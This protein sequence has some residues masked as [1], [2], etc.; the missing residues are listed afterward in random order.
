MYACTVYMIPEILKT[1]PV[2][3]NRSIFKIQL[4]N[5]PE[6]TDI[7][8]VS[9]V[10]KRDETTID[11][12]S[13]LLRLGRKYKKADL[14][15]EEPV[16][17]PVEE[18]LIR[19]PKE[20]TKAEKVALDANNELSE[21]IEDLE[22]R[23]P[24]STENLS[25]KASSYYMTN[26]KKY[27]REINTLFKSYIKDLD[28]DK[29]TLKC[30]AEQSDTFN[31]LTHQKIVRDYINIYTPYRG[32]LLY[33]GLGSGKTCSSIAIAEGMKSDRRI[34]IMT[35]ASL[36]MNFFNE[37]KHCGDALYKKNQYWEFV[38]AKDVD[39]IKILSTTLQLPKAYVKKHGGAW[40]V[41]VR[42]PANFSSLGAAEQ[43]QLDDQLNEMIRTKYTDI[44]YNGITPTIM[45]RITGK[46]TRNPFDNS[47]VV[48]DEAHNFVSRIVNK[49]KRKSS[50]TYKL[51]NY[52][53]TAQNARLVFLS[54][55]PIINYPNEIAVLYNMLRG[56][57]VS[58][59][60]PITN[61]SSEKI[62]NERIL[63]VF[64]K[65]G[66]RTYDYIDYSADKLTITRN[67]FGFVNLKKPGVLRGTQKTIRG[68]NINGSV[69]HGDAREDSDDESIEDT[70]IEETPI[71]DNKVHEN[72]SDVS[73]DSDSDEEP[74]EKEI[75][76]LKRQIEELNR[77]KEEDAR[78]I[79]EDA[80]AERKLGQEIGSSEPGIF[81]RA[82]NYIR[83]FGGARTQKQRVVNNKTKKVR[84]SVPAYF[85]K[86]NG[87]KL[88]DQGNISDDAFIGTVLDI[89]NKHDLSVDEKTVVRNSYTALP[90]N[91]GQFNEMFV[92][93]E[94]KNIINA[95]VLK[96][97]ILGLT[98]HF[99]SAQEEL[100]PMVIK[101]PN[102][103][104]IFVV[105]T[106]M[107]D[108]QFSYYQKVRQ[109]E[110]DQEKNSAK[111]SARV[112]DDDVYKFTSTYRIFSR[113]ACN[114]VFPPGMKRPVPKKDNDV[115][116]D[117]FDA[118]TLKELE[119]RSDYNAEDAGTKEQ[120]KNKAEATK[121]YQKD[122]TKSLK[123]LAKKT[124][125]T[126]VHLTRDKLMIYSPK[127]AS[128]LENIES[129]ENK[130]LHLIYTQFRTIEG[131]GIMKLVL[132]A[133]GYTEFKIKKSAGGKWSVVETDKDKG[134]PKFALYTGTESDDEKEI[135][136]NLYNSNWDAI[137]PEL[138]AYAKDI[139][140]NN[141][142]G[143]VIKVFMIT[144]SGAEGIS[145]KNTRFV[146]I[147]EPYW[148]MVRVRQVIGRARRICSHE[149][150]PKP[151]RT[152]KV[153]MYQ[154]VLSNEQKTSDKNIELRIRDVSKIDR[155]TPVTTDE[156]IYETA[157]IK[158][159]INNQILDAVKSSAFD[160]TLY[161]SRR[162]GDDDPIACYSFGK[163]ESNDFGTVPDIDIDKNERTELNVRNVTWSATEVTYKGKLYALNDETGILYDMESYNNAVQGLGDM[164][165]VGNVEYKDDKPVINID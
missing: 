47:V 31:L 107:S 130:G 126:S 37:L 43:K 19:I 42:K 135:I 145:L 63:E 25:I 146:H 94:T 116:E 164:I 4:P 129:S 78:R 57:I 87:V 115:S 1:R 131:V 156:S 154:A 127:F 62:N 104:D 61:K 29:A 153:F 81:E 65:E 119:K 22:V 148:H 41:D 28:S 30:G 157:T 114:F 110:A 52:L 155:N 11:R 161:A 123:E 77:I 34:Y 58:W 162:T 55:T 14:Q 18:Q 90:D 82:Q 91:L 122:I 102:G 24:M 51:Y 33:H 144:S 56:S 163:T 46:G 50:D 66:L 16:E 6:Y 103:D 141:F 97:R 100:M 124:R 128:V 13:I 7:R 8:G 38:P 165:A 75:N 132:E 72:D 44:N 139:H 120:V 60:I 93:P 53:M 118:M 5:Q 54:G 49:L 23:M 121:E 96:R 108:H 143:Q 89:L 106:P 142:M 160:C 109:T 86:Y 45:S 67:P 98:S 73:E 158:E 21:P 133:N 99:R 92:D 26:R 80:I 70:P 27:I 40:L 69:S 112:D 15:A 3:N 39:R 150:L 101:T 111:K 105:K 20:K 79:Q 32:L 159:T 9:I 35:P 68:G 36:K 137:P 136:R 134:K 83:S 113:A 71:E 17:E 149:D 76:A 59:T 74:I 95:D 48:I 125:G 151:L 12:E 85:E 147:L 152:V 138:A 10:D 140:K 2:P 84:T 64:D 117:D 88:D